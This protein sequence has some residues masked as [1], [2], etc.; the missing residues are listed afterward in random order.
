MN[1][2]SLEVNEALKA[3]WKETAKLLK[4]SE[5]RQY[6]AKVVGQ[7]GHGGQ[8]WVQ[9]ELG[10][11]RGT[12]RKGQ[13][14]VASGQPIR[15]AFE[16]RGRKPVEE[17]MPQLR[18]QIRAIVEPRTQADPSLQSSRVYARISAA[19]VRQ[20]LVERYSY[21]EE[22]LP[23]AEWIRRR[24]NR[25]GYRLKR[26]QKTKPQK[27][28]PETAAILTKVSEVNQ[29]ADADPKTLRISIDAKATVKIG[30]Y[31]RGG[32]HAC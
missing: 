20:E 14:E 25:M 27:V 5:R 19:K 9:R 31:D 29:R 10:W 2:K 1:I 24:L 17:K 13:Q 6:M 15:D 18:E 3:L 8:V 32:T 28:I 4:G 11:N 21:R 12:I 26:V 23:S 22:E 7:L 16:R 30:D